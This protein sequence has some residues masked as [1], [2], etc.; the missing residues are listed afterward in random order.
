M[1]YAWN[2]E[3]WFGILR[4]WSQSSRSFRVKC[5]NALSSFYTSSCGVPSAL[6]RSFTF[7]Q[8]SHL[9]HFHESSLSCRWHSTLLLSSFDSSVIRQSAADTFMDY[10]KSFNS[11]LLQYWILAQRTQKATMRPYVTPHSI[12]PTLLATLA[13]FFMNSWL[14]KDQILSY[15]TKSC[16]YLI[17]IFFNYAVSDLLR[18]HYSA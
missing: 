18:L 11:K 8:Y 1:R 14:F 3:S 7:K 17:I 2:F 16:Y 5:D 15:L 9:F 10:C 12:S 13:S 6:L 4:L